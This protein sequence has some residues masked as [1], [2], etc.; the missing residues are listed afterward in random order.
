MEFHCCLATGRHRCSISFSGSIF[1]FSLYMQ[2]GQPM[3]VLHFITSPT[4]VDGLLCFGPHRYVGRLYIKVYI[5]LWTTSWRQFKSDCH[6]TWSVIPLAKG[7]EVIKF[8][9]VKG[10]GRWGGYA[11]Y[12]TLFYFIKVF[13]P[14]LSAVLPGEPRSASSLWFSSSAFCRTEF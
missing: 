9:K 13:L 14:V 6:Q 1:S 8:W 11:L 2:Y 12:W 5:C 3:P 7:D 4:K 10:R